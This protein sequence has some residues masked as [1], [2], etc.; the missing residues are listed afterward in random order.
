M[1]TEADVQVKPRR[2]HRQQLQALSIPGTSGLEMAADRTQF[3]QEAVTIWAAGNELW[4]G[5]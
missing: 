1:D 2:I 4:L 3:L 5:V